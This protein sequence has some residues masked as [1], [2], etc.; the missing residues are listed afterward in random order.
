MWCARACNATITVIAVIVNDRSSSVC[1][2]LY[3]D[4]R[5]CATVRILF[6]D[7]MTVLIVVHSVGD[8]VLVV[9]G[10]ASGCRDADVEMIDPGGPW[11]IGQEQKQ[12][13]SIS[14]GSVQIQI[15]GNLVLDS[16]SFP[17]LLRTTILVALQ[18]PFHSLYNTFVPFDKT[19]QS[20]CSLP[21]SSLLLSSPPL[22]RLFPYVALNRR[23]LPH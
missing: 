7:E 21:L 8:C 3:G 15:E 17:P 1:K 19:Q 6:D 20:P 4:L 14:A 18:R 10:P 11:Q 2:A 9:V 12:E 22:S 5:L 13:R 16:T 23:I